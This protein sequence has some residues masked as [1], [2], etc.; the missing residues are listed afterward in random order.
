MIDQSNRAGKSLVITAFKPCGHEQLHALR[1]QINKGFPKIPR[2]LIAHL[3]APQQPQ[4]EPFNYSIVCVPIYEGERDRSIIE[5]M[6]PSL[7]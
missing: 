6:S 1:A 2:N 3:H 4:L 7:R 5:V